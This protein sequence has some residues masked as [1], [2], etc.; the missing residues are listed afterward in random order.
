ME[1]RWKQTQGRYVGH[2]FS[3]KSTTVA[4]TEDEEHLHSY[5]ADDG[6]SGGRVTV[7]VVMFVVIRSGE[8]DVVGDGDSY[9]ECRKEDQPIPQCFAHAVM[10]Q[11]EA[12]FLHRRHLVFWESWL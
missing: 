5:V 3:T 7:R 11:N 10:K 6:G 8:A 4:H 2:Q 9:I 1:Q 12:G